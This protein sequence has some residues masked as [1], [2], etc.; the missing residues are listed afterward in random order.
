MT[1]TLLL[2]IGLFWVSAVVQAQV[3]STSGPKPISGTIRDSISNRPLDRAVVS[4]VE[5][6]QTDTARYLT[7]AQG[8]FSIDKAPVGEFILIVSNVGFQTRGIRYPA[9]MAGELGIV[10]L[11]EKIREL[12]EIVIEAPPIKVL[13]D[14]VEYRANAFPVRKD[15]VAEDVFKK[16]PGV[17]V[18]NQGN[19]TAHGQTV[20]KI[21]VN[22]KDFFGGDPKMASKNIPADAIDKIQV[23]DD[24]SDQ[25]KF[26]GFDD[27]DRTK[28]INITIKKDRNQGIFGSA[29]VGAGTT[30]AGSD[31]TAGTSTGT[32]NTETGPNTGSDA[33]RYEGF[34]RAFRFNN[35]EQMAILGNANNI[36]L[37]TFTQ[38]GA[39]FQGGGGRGGGGGGGS[40]SPSSNLTSGNPYQTGYNDAKVIGANYANDF[41]PHLTLFG[42]YQYSQTKSTI[43]TSTY[44]QYLGDVPG[45]TEP[46]SNA[47]SNTYTI[48]QKHS[49]YLNFGW[50]FSKH[51][52]LLLR[53]SFTYTSNSQRAIST[54]TYED[55]LQNPID[56]I[57]Q[58]YAGYNTSPSINGTA[59]WMHKFNKAGRTLS[60]TVTDNPTPQ[61]E[62]DTNYS[63]QT[64][65]TGPVPSDTIHQLSFF[66]TNNYTYSARLSYT[67]P[68][69]RKTGIELS[70]S[71]SNSENV[72]SKN[73]YSL[74]PK[75][76]QTYVDSLSNN[77]DNYLIT[78]K[79][80][81]T[82]R[83]KERKFNYQIGVAAQP[84]ELYSKTMFPNS[85]V[86]S[87]YTR[88]EF[89]VVPI[90]QLAYTFSTTKRLRIFYTG[91]SQ[92]PSPSQLQPVPDYTNQQTINYGNPLLKPAFNNHLVI[93]YNNFSNVS[94][95]SFFFNINGNYISNY[96]TSNTMYEANNVHYIVPVN[97]SGYYTYS[98]YANLSQPFHNRE[99]ILTLI[100]K[101]AYANNISY[102]DSIKEIERNWQPTGTV[103]FEWDK[104]DWLEIIGGAS[105]NLNS[106]VFIVPQ[107]AV[108]K[109]F[110]QTQNTSPSSWTFAQSSRIDFLKI[111]SIRYD[112]IYTI[113]Q[114][115]VGSI[116]SRPISLLNVILETRF[117]NQNAIVGLSV[118]D[119][120]NQNASFNAGT[121][122]GVY[123]QTQTNILQR[124]FMLTFT[125]KFAKFKGAQ[126]MPG[127]GNFR[128]MR[129]GGGG[130]GRMGG[131]PPGGPSSDL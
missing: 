6:G 24:Q 74:Y 67:E 62:I 103:R 96:I 21:R 70:Y 97:T 14:T 117:M 115:L 59:L 111:F 77:L 69:S 54:T 47:Y 128:M 85:P 122:N 100:G 11:G 66:N 37:N 41:T 116:G 22:G 7:N 3:D 53:P 13:Q 25:A 27:G 126:Q 95:R 44:S 68:L 72:S 75:L 79:I 112:Y 93:N 121:S 51:D 63:A 50:G 65:L 127:G 39:S 64:Y 90:G 101:L 84:T 60:I 35:N 46:Y 71:Y 23:I 31:Q 109:G 61:R 28:I 125:Y 106:N 2:F 113:N 83:E 20:T 94:G 110:E 40:T 33:N 15:A 19:I 4:Y 5:L 105:Y 99:F 8:R 58:N 92:Q 124:F 10:Y 78:N 55:S 104:G 30:S 34:V 120:L 17:E 1:K 98:G 43:I 91:T 49:A 73:V 57:Y 38:G 76:A 131:G 45:N 80:G 52:S 87:I 88:H 123:T 82:F 56:N 81:L 118:N 107:Q 29:T 36:N 9:S 42:S 32:G 12:G 119:L 48:Q 16:L 108:T 130:G 89:I 129:P 102:E 18:D 86:D 26:S 114:G